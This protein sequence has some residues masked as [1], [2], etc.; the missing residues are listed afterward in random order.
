MRDN[1]L[2]AYDEVKII[3]IGGG[4]SSD[5]NALSLQTIRDSLDPWIKL[6]H[7]KQFIAE[8]GRLFTAD[9]MSLLCSVISKN[10]RNGIQYYVINNSIHHTFSCIIFDLH[11]PKVMQSIDW[12]DWGTDKHEMVDGCIVGETCDGVDVLYHGLVPHDLP[13]GTT[14]F[15][16]CMGAYSNASAN[17]FNGFTKPDVVYYNE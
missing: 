9:C 16:P 4:F 13:L 8:P 7:D 2:D 6:Y 10:I 1:Y 3:D 17:T 12:I 5:E 15:F 14:L 11:I